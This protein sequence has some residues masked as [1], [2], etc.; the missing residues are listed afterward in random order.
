MASEKYFTV[1][2]ESISVNFVFRDLFPT[3]RAIFWSIFRSKWGTDPHFLGSYSFPSLK[4]DAI[5][6]SAS[7]LAQPI[8]DYDSQPIIQFAGEATH[9][10]Y[11]STVHGAIETGWCQA[12]KLIDLYLKRSKL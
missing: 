3:N 11:H 8:L 2:M 12:Q 4:G 10:K 7:T 1:C 5:G 6:A 9:T